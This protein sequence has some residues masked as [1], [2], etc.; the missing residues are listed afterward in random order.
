[1]VLKKQWEYKIKGL[2]QAIASADGVLMDGQLYFALC[3]CKGSF[4]K[5][6]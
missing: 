6:G 1:M 5:A 4:L 2:R 3:Y